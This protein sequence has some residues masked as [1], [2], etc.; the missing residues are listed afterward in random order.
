MS[1]SLSPDSCSTKAAVPDRAMVP[2]F[3]ISSS[4]FMPMPLSAMVMLLFFLS[5]LMLTLY[6]VSSSASSGCVSAA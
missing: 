2:R 3:S 4:W 5:T 1:A 6:S